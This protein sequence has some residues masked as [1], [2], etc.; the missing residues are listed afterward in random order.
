VKMSAPADTII[1]ATVLCLTF[2]TTTAYAIG[3]GDGSR[4][5]GKGSTSGQNIITQ[6]HV[7][8]PGGQPLTTPR[9]KRLRP[10]R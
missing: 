8:N 7:G 2:D 5:D 1:A 6:V 4:G 3:P 10:E 9:L